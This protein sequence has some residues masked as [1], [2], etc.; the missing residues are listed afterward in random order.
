MEVAEQPF[1]R[2]RAKARKLSELATT[3]NNQHELAHQAGRTALDHAYKAGEA[4]NEAYRI[5]GRRSKWGKWRSRNFIGSDET[6]RIYRRIYLNWD[7][8]DVAELRTN[9]RE[10]SI[11]A[12]LRILRGKK[13]DRSFSE[14]DQQADYIR[15]ELRRLWA[16]KIRE[17][18]QQELEAL[19]EAFEQKAWPAIRRKVQAIA[20]ATTPA[21]ASTTVASEGSADPESRRRTLDR[22]DRGR[23]MR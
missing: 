2:G 9:S 20:M 19:S 12:V 4:L 6:A 1:Y 8:P 14:A 13:V 22:L 11:A 18:S 16:A 10:T 7:R 21:S 15:S 23:R 5:N 3:A 17:L